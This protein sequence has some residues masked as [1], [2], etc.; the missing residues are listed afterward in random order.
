MIIVQS[1]FV[2]ALTKFRHILSVCQNIKNIVLYMIYEYCQPQ[3]KAKAKAMPGRLYIH[4]GINN[5]CC[6]LAGVKPTKIV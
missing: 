2:V 5:H 3:A 1:L 4:T 6:V